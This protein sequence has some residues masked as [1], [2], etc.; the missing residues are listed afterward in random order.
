MS[1]SPRSPW[2]LNW[3]ADHSFKMLGIN[4]PAAQHNLNVHHFIYLGIFVF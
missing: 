3:T 2:P 1:Q 4:N